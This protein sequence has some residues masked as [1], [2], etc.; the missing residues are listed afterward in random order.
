MQNKQG[1]ERFWAGGGRVGVYE[2]KML[3]WLSE[4]EKIRHVCACACTL[5][6]RAA[7]YRDCIM[8]WV[9]IIKL[10]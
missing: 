2:T 9:Q 10:L 7:E 8:S 4:A 6:S 1:K 3:E 5:S